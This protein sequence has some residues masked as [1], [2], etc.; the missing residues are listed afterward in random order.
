MSTAT[1]LDLNK[2]KDA[3]AAAVAQKSNVKTPSPN[4]DAALEA[5]EAATIAVQKVQS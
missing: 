5:I 3:L 1:I 2:A 4:L